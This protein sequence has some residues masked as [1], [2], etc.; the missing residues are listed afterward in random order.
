MDYKMKKRMAKEEHAEKRIERRDGGLADRTRK[1]SM[2]HVVKIR[3]HILKTNYCTL[4]FNQLILPLIHKTQII[5]AQIVVLVMSN[6]PNLK[7]KNRERKVREM[8]VVKY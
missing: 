1:G 5:F 3:L 8:H 6:T 2:V 7:N 4:N